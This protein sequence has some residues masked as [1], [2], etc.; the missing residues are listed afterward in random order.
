MAKGDKLIL[1]YDIPSKPIA[2]AQ[3]DISTLRH[4]GKLSNSG[5]L[6]GNLT[7]LVSSN[8]WKFAPVPSRNVV[9]KRVSEV[10][11]IRIDRQQRA[12]RT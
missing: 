11:N 4:L 5:I 6:T 3:Q 2:Q 10:P 7:P 12:L 1:P 9:A 8:P